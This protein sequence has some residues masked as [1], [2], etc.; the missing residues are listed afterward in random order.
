MV[1]FNYHPAL[2]THNIDP[3]YDM[4]NFSYVVKIAMQLA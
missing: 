2:A 3:D 1:N 4:P